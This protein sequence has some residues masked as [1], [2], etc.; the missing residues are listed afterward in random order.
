MNLLIN[1]SVLYTRSHYV[2]QRGLT[3]RSVCF[4]LLRTENK[5]FIEIKK[6]LMGTQVPPTVILYLYR[7]LEIIETECGGTERPGFLGHPQLSRLHRT[8]CNLKKS[9]FEKLPNFYCIPKF[10]IT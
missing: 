7:S 3:L 1:Y 8:H 10:K 5:F 4:C 2:D 9:S 6:P